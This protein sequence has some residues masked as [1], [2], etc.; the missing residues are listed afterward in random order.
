MVSCH[1]YIRY[2]YN[3]RGDNWD[4]DCKVGHMQS[5]IDIKTSSAFTSLD[6]KAY[7]NLKDIDG[8]QLYYFHSILSVIYTEGRFTFVDKDEESHWKSVQFHFHAPAEHFVD[9]YIYDAEMHV[10][11]QNEVDPEKLLVTAIFIQNDAEAKPSELIESLQLQNITEGDYKRNVKLNG[12][13][14]KFN[15]ATTY[16]LRGSLTF[17]PCSEVVRWVVIGE[18]LKVPQYQIDY[19]NKLWPHN[20]KFAHGYGNIRKVQDSNDRIIH[21]FNFGENTTQSIQ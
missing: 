13:Y 20:D 6:H 4:G 19:L 10:V 7:G 14:Q 2:D 8:A 1:S 18:P 17:P 5:P 12:F 9:G 15:G 3:Q 11:L 21:S 16:T